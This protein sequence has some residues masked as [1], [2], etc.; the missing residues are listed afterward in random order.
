MT[1]TLPSAEWGSEGADSLQ[2]STDGG[3]TWT[4]SAVLAFDGPTRGD[5]NCP[6]TRG[7]HDEF[8]LHQQR[9]DHRRQQRLCRRGQPQNAAAFDA[10]VLPTVKV[11]LENSATGLII[12][13][14]L[15]STTARS[16]V[17]ASPLIRRRRQ[18][19]SP[20]RRPTPIICRSISSRPEPSMPR[21]PCQ[22]DR[23]Q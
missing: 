20:G 10:L 18:R 7:T 9:D 17:R 16:P 19:S 22:A 1:P 11:T 12:D 21:S 13:Q 6:G 15:A 8:Q 4:S 5:T 2:V 3:Q 23:S 14:G